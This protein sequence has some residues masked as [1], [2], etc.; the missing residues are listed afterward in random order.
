MSARDVSVRCEC[1]GWE[2][3]PCLAYEGVTVYK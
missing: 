2:C 3:D 1:E